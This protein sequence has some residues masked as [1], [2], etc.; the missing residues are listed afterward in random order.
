ML[1]LEKY[2]G[3]STRHTCPDCGTA[4]TFTRYIDPDT[5]QHLA[6]DVGR[7]DRETS[8]SYHKPPREYYAENYGY[9]RHQRNWPI[10]F[11]GSKRKNRSQSVYEAK[12]T[13][14]RPQYLDIKHLTASL[15]NYDRNNF[16]IF[17]QELFPYDP[18][19]AIEAANEY[20]IG[21]GNNGEAIFW[22]I[23]Q[24][25]NIRTGKLIAYDP[26]TG[27]R[28][29]DKRPYWIHSAL[30]KSGELSE[31]F[32]LQQCFFGEHLLPKYPDRLIGIVEA[33]KTAVIASICEGV[34]T[35]TV[36]LACGGLTQLNKDKLERI[37]RNKRRIVLYPD[38]NGYDK[39]R[40][41]ASEAR[42][43]GIQVTVSDLLERFATSE[44][45]NEGLDLADFLIT[46]QQ[47]RND[48]ENR[49]AFQELIEE[50][51]AI[52]MFDGGVSEDEAE[53]AIKDSGFYADAISQSLVVTCQ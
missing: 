2:K 24:Q 32:D 25:D 40:S 8:C 6:E 16:L 41:I 18:H 30:K 9:T 14:Q 20:R 37:G 4:K 34:F 17:I 27:K 26:L 39:W 35:D 11:I 29:K 45:K 48:P 38:L 46:E 12:I 3:P 7:C 36:W 51:L 15:G 31:S 28:R 53:A 23:D 13:I 50:R 49:K 1:T 10:P 19:T 43:A 44:Q 42:K 22:Q 33:E 52:M 47:K 21:T 5:G